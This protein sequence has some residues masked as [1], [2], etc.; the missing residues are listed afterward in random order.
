MPTQLS[1]IEH[2]ALVLAPVGHDD[3]LTPDVLARCSVLPIVCTSIEEV[4]TE[5]NVGAGTIIL[6][7]ESLDARDFPQLKTALDRQPAWSD[8][9]VVLLAGGERASTPMR[10]AGVAE[11]LGNVT[12]M[13]RPVRASGLVSVVRAAIRSRMRQYEMRDT[14]GALRA[15]REEAEAAS[16]VRD[17]FLATLSH[18]LRTPL[19]AILGWT[20][21]LRQGQVAPKRVEKALEVVERNARAQAGIIE[22]ALDMARIITGKLRLEMGPVALEPIVKAGVDA[23]RPGA[24]AKGVRL[25]STIS[26]VPAIRGDAGR[27]QQVFWNL[28]S[29]AVKFTP[30]GGEVRVS[31]GLTDSN[32]I[33]TVSDT[34]SGL[35]PDFLPFVFDRFRQADQSVTRRHGG[36]G[37]GLSIV[38]HLLELHGSTVKAQSAGVGNGATFT[39]SFPV[40]A[41]FE[42]Q[43]NRRAAGSRNGGPLAVCLD[44]HTVLVVDDDA[45]TRELLSE[46]LT[47]AGARVST[48][49]C[50]AAAFAAIRKD[51]PHV[52][53]ADLRMP[54]EDGCSLMRR[55]RSLPTPA[56][57]VPAV[58]LSAYTRAEDRTSAQEAGFSTFIAKP[59][60]SQ[61]LLGALQALAGP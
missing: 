19:N 9:P 61:E 51:P 14:L 10:M 57:N 52:I 50:A 6:S 58:A 27:L 43:M 47:D 36:L 41:V 34:G 29:N 37:L 4:C 56:G 32:V 5:F 2:R 15:A 55:V 25:V 49:D 13:E 1:D 39:V 23:F 59:A 18:E 30:T 16:R 21:M 26:S 54:G 7:E 45:A 20:R 42:V 3:Q 60:R 31:L 33:L 24:E 8:V 22:D 38:K 17:E 35:P 46:F 40:P 11:S 12:V 44:G 48:A 53:V 28:L